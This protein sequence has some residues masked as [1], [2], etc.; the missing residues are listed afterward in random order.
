MPGTILIIGA[1]A[2]GLMAARTAL[3]AG[4]QVTLLE[5]SDRIGG[6]IH[7]I[8]PAGFTQPIEA[9]A[10]FMHGKLPLTM[11][12]LKEAG[13]QYEPMK[14]A[15]IRVQNGQWSA[16]EEFTIG[17]DELMERMGE[18]KEDLT[19]ANFLQRY[20]GDDKYKALRQSVQRFAEGFDLADINKA[21]TLAIYEEWKNEQ[22]EQYGIPAGYTQLMQFLQQD[23]IG[24]GCSMHT[25]C[26]VTTIR[27]QA[28]HVQVIT[29][30]G[31]EFNAAK[32][33]ITVPL[34][35]LQAGAINFEP[36]IDNYIEAARQIG[37]GSV[38]KVHLQFK[39]AFWYS[40]KKDI[41]FLLSNETV[42]TWW[43]HYPDQR[44]LL[45]GWLGDPQTEQLYKAGEQSILQY[46]LQSLSN[47]FKETSGALSSLL[48]AWH[49]INWH[50]VPH[51]SGAYSYSTLTTPAARE[52]LNTA[53][54]Q[55]VFFAG[56]ACYDGAN[57]GTVE[58]ALVSGQQAAAMLS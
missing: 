5:A 14:G 54:E 17:W 27:W 3:A 32:L 28:G 43:T 23:C 34:G 48:T 8:Q 18:L 41:G 40:Y 30:N 12:L 19:L 24:K 2:A 35:V 4:H 16:Q 46:S 11:Q 26:A 31:R 51:I 42:P 38:I 47:I 53:I 15:M 22:D 58:A 50:D 56:E 36:A 52:L 49:V 29:N 57:G 6:R 7:T 44:P 13:M 33:I 55:T 9:G 20:F 39:E 21:S 25:S 37:Y 45:T 1:G 10:E